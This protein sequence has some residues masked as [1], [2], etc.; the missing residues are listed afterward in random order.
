MSGTGRDS[1]RIRAAMS[2]TGRPAL[3]KGVADPRGLL[4]M[5]QLPLAAIQFDDFSVT[6]TNRPKIR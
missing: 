4:P 2:G 5:D 3:V 6:I 1:R